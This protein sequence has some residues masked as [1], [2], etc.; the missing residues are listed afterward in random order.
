MVLMTKRSTD[1]GRAEQVAQ[2]GD[3]LID[4]AQQFERLAAETRRDARAVRR[5]E[6]LADFAAA[7]GRNRVYRLEAARDALNDLHDQIC[8]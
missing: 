3:A 4:L 2:V 6:L 1:G 7:Y 8:R 5:G